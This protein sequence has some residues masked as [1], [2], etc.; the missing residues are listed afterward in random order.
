MISQ[1]MNLPFL[2][3]C[4]EAR[5]GLILDLKITAIAYYLERIAQWPTYGNAGI[6]LSP[7]N[8]RFHP[9]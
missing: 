4:I 2:V 7:P 9:G 3:D 1:M 5:A 6:T 8:S